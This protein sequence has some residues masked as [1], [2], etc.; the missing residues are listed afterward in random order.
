MSIAEVEA[1]A[2]E[3]GIEVALVRRAARELAEPSR[4]PTTA[5]DARI[6]RLLGAPTALRFEATV[7]GEITDTCFDELVHVIHAHLGEFG[8]ASRAGRSLNW[9]TTV[10][11]NQPGRRIG[12][13]VTVAG[14]RT[15]VRIDERLQGLIGGL[16]GGL[17]GG[18]GGG[19]MGL[20]A[21]PL[22]LAPVLTPIFVGGWLGGTYLL[23]R[24]I[25]A[26][27]VRRRE[28]ELAGLLT[29]LVGVC[30]DG[31]TPSTTQVSTA[32]LALAAASS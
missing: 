28:A 26:R 8:T 32:A 2:S 9:Q 17:V 30:E 4:A 20:I 14:G 15:H 23:A 24:R 13:S 27:Q 31:A 12:V 19:G 18:L 7:P 1:V 5:H 16:F 21:L 6:H 22:A 25:Y 11:P 3:A 29:R 10:V